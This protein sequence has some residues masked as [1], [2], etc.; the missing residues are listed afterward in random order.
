LHFVWKVKV[1][2]GDPIYYAVILA[3]LLAFRIVWHLKSAAAASRQ[4]SR[5]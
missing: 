5:A 1:V 2:V 3:G 4:T